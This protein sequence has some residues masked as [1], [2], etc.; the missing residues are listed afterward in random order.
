MNQL[1]FAD[2]PI[3]LKPLLRHTRLHFSSDPWLTQEAGCGMVLQ[4]VM[5]ISTLYAPKSLLLIWS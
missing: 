2:L 4:A 1:T 3:Y 5:P